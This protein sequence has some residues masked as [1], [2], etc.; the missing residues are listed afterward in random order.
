LGH[1]LRGM[2][3]K[4]FNVPAA[5]TNAAETVVL[6][7]LTNDPVTRRARYQLVIRTTR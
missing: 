7:K 3:G 6:R 2:L 1:F 4:T 5:D